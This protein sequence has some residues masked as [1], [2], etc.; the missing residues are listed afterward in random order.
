MA[1]RSSKKAQESSS[2][3]AFEEF[4]D[5]ADGYEE[6]VPDIKEKE[7]LPTHRSRD[8]RDVERLRELRELRKLVGDDFDDVLDDL[9]TD[10]DQPAAGKKSRRR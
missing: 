5:E 2:P 10:G 4:D 9:I 6:D 7:S 1:G 3:K 8:W